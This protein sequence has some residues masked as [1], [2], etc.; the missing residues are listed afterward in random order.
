[1]IDREVGAH[2]R[3]V[4]II[5]GAPISMCSPPLAKDTIAQLAPARI[6][7]NRI[8]V[9]PINGPRMVSTTR[10]RRQ[11]P[12]LEP[13]AVPPQAASQQRHMAPTPLCLPPP[14]ANGRTRGT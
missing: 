5:T 10:P 11:P 3:G 9:L 4:A 14:P 1:M 6:V 2:V 13:I 8:V 12:T 7:I